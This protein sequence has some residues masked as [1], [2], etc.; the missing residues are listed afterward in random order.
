MANKIKN[1]LDWYYQRLVENPCKHTFKEYVA[2][3]KE[4]SDLIYKMWVNDLISDKV[5]EECYK[6]L[7]EYGVKAMK[8]HNL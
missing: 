8:Y 3:D 4:L 7:K 1:T 6:V 5:K 2:K